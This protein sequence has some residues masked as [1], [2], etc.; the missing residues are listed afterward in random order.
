MNGT[1]ATAQMDRRLSAD[2]LHTQRKREANGAQVAQLKCRPVAAKVA[3]NIVPGRSSRL[4]LRL[5][6]GLFAVSLR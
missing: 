6:C 4:S 1:A 3:S 5:V 2:G